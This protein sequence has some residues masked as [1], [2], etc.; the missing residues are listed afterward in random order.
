M[1]DCSYTSFST[2]QSFGLGS[3][4]LVYNDWKM[5]TSS[6]QK[7]NRKKTMRSAYFKFSQ[8][9][10]YSISFPM[11][12]FNDIAIAV[13]FQ[14]EALGKMHLLSKTARLLTPEISQTNLWQKK[15]ENTCNNTVWEKKICTI[16][17]I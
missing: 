15:I 9:V 6:H 11:K 3:L 12:K 8:N 1:C 2:G 10:A 7:S 13:R 16:A 4:D 14:L 5:C 17:A